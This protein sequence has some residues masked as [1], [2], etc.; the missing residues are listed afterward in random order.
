MSSSIKSLN[1]LRKIAPRTSLF[2]PSLRYYA[3]PVSEGK[4]HYKVLVAGGGT[5]GCAVAGRL[6][7]A[8]Q[9][10]DLAVIEPREVSPKLSPLT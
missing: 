3:R 10:G 4:N 6:R 8:V 7:D 1:V 9:H 5:G 2:Q